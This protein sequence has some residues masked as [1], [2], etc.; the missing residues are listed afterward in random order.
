MTILMDSTGW[1]EKALW[2]I[3]GIQAIG[4]STIVL[5]AALQGNKS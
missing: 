5:T 1:I 4:S 3:I 2:Y